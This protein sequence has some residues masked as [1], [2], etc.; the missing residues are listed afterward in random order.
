V[1]EQLQLDPTAKRGRLMLIAGPDHAEGAVQINQDASVFVTEVSPKQTI[2]HDLGQGRHAWVQ[3][4]RGAASVNGASVK[5][6]DAVSLSKEEK[7][8]IVGE[9]SEPSEL[10]IFDLN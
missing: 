1:Y 4:V 2:S 6:G 7:I 5:T 3:V 9:G 10:L 8:T